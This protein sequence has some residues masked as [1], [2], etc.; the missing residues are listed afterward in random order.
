MMI[1]IAMELVA[2]VLSF[3]IRVSLSRFCLIS[4][5]WSLISLSLSF[6]SHLISFAPNYLIFLNCQDS[7]GVGMTACYQSFEI[8]PNFFF[9]YSS[10]VLMSHCQWILLLMSSSDFY[11]SILTVKTLNKY[12]RASEFPISNVKQSNWF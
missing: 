7:I 11:C 2:W 8:W 3:R 4:D 6:V 5:L 1:C 9:F 12:R 10:S